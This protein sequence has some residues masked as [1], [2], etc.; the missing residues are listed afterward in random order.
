[1]LINRVPRPTFLIYRLVFSQR[2]CFLNI[3]IHVEAIWA[4]KATMQTIDFY[5]V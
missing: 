1:M 3:F 5:I 2:N 4:E